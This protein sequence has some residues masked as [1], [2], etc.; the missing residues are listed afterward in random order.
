M[1]EEY[2]IERDKISKGILN[3]EFFPYL[4]EY[5]KDVCP[6]PLI[7]DYRQFSDMFAKYLDSPLLMQNGNIVQPAEQFTYTLPKILEHLDK[8]Y[9]T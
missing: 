9:E 1:N 4:F 2:K 7:S 3:K 5:Y 8:K 6:N